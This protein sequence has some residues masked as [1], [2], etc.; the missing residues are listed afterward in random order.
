[1]ADFCK[2]C[3]EDIFGEDYGDLKGLSSVEDTAK[4]MYAVVICEGCGPTQ[5]DHNGVCVGGCLNDDEEQR[6]RFGLR[7]H[8]KETTSG[9]D[10][11]PLS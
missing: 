7:T 1:M 5:V 10:Q 2:L 8:T 6:K 4:G 11:T 9:N 3:S